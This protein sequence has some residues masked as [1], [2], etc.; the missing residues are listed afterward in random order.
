MASMMMSNIGML[1]ADAARAAR[2]APRGIGHVK[3]AESRPLSSGNDLPLTPYVFE[4]DQ[5]ATL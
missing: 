4:R 3:D 1:L 5:A 2:P